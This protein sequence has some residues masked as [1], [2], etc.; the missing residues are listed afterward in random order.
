MHE[1]SLAPATAQCFATL[2]K[3][4]FLKGFYLAGG[5]AVA[6][7]LGHQQ[8][9]GLDFFSTKS[10]NGL[11][12]R[13]ALAALGDFKLD[14]E[15][16]GTLHGNLNGVKL[17]FLEYAYPLLE[18]TF[19]YQGVQVPGL[20]DL[21]AM[22]C[23]ALAARGKKRDF[24]DLYIL[25]QQGM[26][27]KEILLYFENKYSSLQYNLSHVIKSFTY[28][29]DADGDPDPIFLK[30]ISWDEVKNFFKR[31]SVKLI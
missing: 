22:K 24:I 12:L 27:L 3:Q 18:Q 29:K 14:Q 17:S 26:S 31:E 20:K 5:T 25:A 4:D 19:D 21:A 1:E 13:D 9:E 16:P 8:S 11:S 30:N 7:H 6:L 2:K 23:D 10:F 15:S 28:F